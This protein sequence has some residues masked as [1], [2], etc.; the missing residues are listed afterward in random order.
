VSTSE[1][2][3]FPELVAELPTAV[4]EVTLKQLTSS[5]EVPESPGCGTEVCVQLDPF[6]VSTRFTLAE[7]AVVAGPTA[8][9]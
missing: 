2:V 8:T 7:P 9:Q 1:D 6:Q 4:H 5:R 3:V